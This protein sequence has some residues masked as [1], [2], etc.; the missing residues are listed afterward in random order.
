M[1]RLRAEKVQRVGSFVEEPDIYGD[2]AGDVL[3][4]SWGST[5]GTVLTVVEQ[6]RREGK[7]V[8]FYHLRWINPLP[9]N[10]GK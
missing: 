9:Q 5:Y 4:A 7:K 1:T 8:S 3:V 2:P 6:L 10:L